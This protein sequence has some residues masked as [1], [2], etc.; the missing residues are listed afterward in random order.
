MDNPGIDKSEDS[1]NASHHRKYQLIQF[2]EELH[3]IR[4]DK[5]YNYRKLTVSTMF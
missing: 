3:E 2:K 5:S 4:L 1:M